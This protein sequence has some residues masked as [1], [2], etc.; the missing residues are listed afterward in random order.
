MSEPVTKLEQLWI[1]KGQGQVHV[2]EVYPGGW[3]LYQYHEGYNG[4]GR[5]ETKTHP[6]T[7]MHGCDVHSVPIKV[8]EAVKFARTW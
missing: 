3:T 7:Q 4:R 1:T 8:R 2:C 6:F 5:W